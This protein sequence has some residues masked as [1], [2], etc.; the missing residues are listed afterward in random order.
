MIEHLGGSGPDL[1]DEA[2]ALRERAFA[3]A[4][5]P[6]TYI[7]IPGLG[8]FVRRAIP[9]TQPFPFVPPVPDYLAQVY[10]AFGARRMMRAEAITRR[11][12]VARATRTRCAWCRP[13]SPRWP[14]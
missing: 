8:E 4:R 10:R 2:R 9:V 7:K 11:W 5:F 14:G 3:L 13:S 12:P 6:N 1:D